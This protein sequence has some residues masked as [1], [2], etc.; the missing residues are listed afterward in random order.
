MQ[1]QEIRICQKRKKQIHSN[2]HMSS[3]QNQNDSDSKVPF[4][5]ATDL[6]YDI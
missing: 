4:S 3:G 6:L 2:T 1:I 5:S